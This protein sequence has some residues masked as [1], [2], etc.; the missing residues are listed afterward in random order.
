LRLANWLASIQ[1]LVQRR[2]GAYRQGQQDA[3]IVG[4]AIS[5]AAVAA[6]WCSQKNEARPVINRSGGRISAF[7][8][9]AHEEWGIKRE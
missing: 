3:I 5:A 6:L 2:F 8:A 4:S 7:R 9:A 1:A